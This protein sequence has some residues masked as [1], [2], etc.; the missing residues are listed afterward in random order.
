MSRIDNIAD[1]TAL[2]LPLEDFG[3]Q[4]DSRTGEA[5]EQDVE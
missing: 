2:N 4:L 3:S 5:D 1:S